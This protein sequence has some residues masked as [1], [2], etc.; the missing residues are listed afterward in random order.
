MSSTTQFKKIKQHT[1]HACA[2]EEIYKVPIA[3]K[4]IIF[5][6][7]TVISRKNEEKSHH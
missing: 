4:F 5:S 1:R 7:E 6:I 2:S 3:L